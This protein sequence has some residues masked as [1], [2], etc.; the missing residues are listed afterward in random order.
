MNVLFALAHWHALAKLQ[1]HTDSSL[2]ILESVT[3]ELGVLLRNFKDTTCSRYD[4]RELD[5]EAAARMRQT[6]SDSTSKQNSN[7]GDKISSTDDDM[8]A[9]T[10][11]SHPEATTTKPTKTSGKLRMTLNLITYKDHSLGDYV[12]SIRRYGTVDS[13]STEA[14]S[15]RSFCLLSKLTFPQMELEHKS[16]KTCYR[17]TSRKCFEKQ[18]GNIER[19]Q[20]CIRRIRQRLNHSGQIQDVLMHEKGLESSTSSY[21]IG[22]TQNH[23]VGL[24]A[25]A[26]QADNDYAA[27]VFIYKTVSP[28]HI[29]ITAS[30]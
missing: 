19:C 27:K 26:R 13:Y 10:S 6:T 28:H 23:P 3:T 1:Q 24:I 18:L 30:C 20:A 9:Y 16:P 14:V 17:R 21:H 2:A 11:T 15:L 25:I 29:L 7:P 5:R 4:T 8:P 12:E 22:N